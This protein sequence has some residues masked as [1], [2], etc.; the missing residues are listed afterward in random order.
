MAIGDGIRRDIS[1]VSEE[2]RDRF[3]GAIVKLDTTKFF[4]DSVSYWD[5]Q[6]DIHKKPR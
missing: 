5:K 3:I 2:E 6:E 4:P 1:L